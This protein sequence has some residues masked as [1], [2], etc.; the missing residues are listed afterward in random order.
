MR[1][2][3]R[4]ANGAS[5]LVYHVDARTGA[6]LRIEDRMKHQVAPATG[7][8]M[9]TYSGAVE[10]PTSLMA[11]GTYALFDTTRGT[12]P[13]PYLSNFTPDESGWGATGMQAWYEEHDAAGVAT[14]NAWL[15][16]SN[17]VNTWGDGQPFTA[18]GQE[19]G[20]NG[21][22]AGVDAMHGMAG[23]WDFF[24][25]VM[26]RNGMDGQ[27][28][29][30]FAQ[31]LETGSYNRD[32]ASWSPWYNGLFLGAGSW[33]GNPNGLSALS[34]FDV[35]A[36]EMTHGVTSSTV[37]FTNAPGYEEA[38]LDEATSDFFAQ[39]AKAYA[40]RAAED[41]PA[42]VP[43]TGADWRV[44]Y[45]AGHGTPIRWMDRPSKDQ[46]SP[47]G[48]YD[49]LLYLD[50]HY[51]SGPL[52]RALYFLAHGA[53]TTAGA[54]DFSVYMPQGMTGIGNDKAAHIWFV[55]VTERLYSGNTGT[56]T[57]A[58]ARK[59]AIEAAKNLYGFGWDCPESIAV[60]N[61]FGAVNV[62]RA[63]GEAPRTQ[64][65]FADW[66]DNDWIVRNHFSDTGYGHK[67]YLPMGVAVQPKITVLNNADT[68]VTWSTGG[69]SVYN[70]GLTPGM[71]GYVTGG[72]VINA[73]G[74]W[75]TP[76]E[77]GWF[78]ITATSKADPRQF[79]EGRAFI[80]NMDADGDNQQDAVD[81]GP[82]AF[83]WYLTQAVNPAHSM[84][85]API[86]DDAD[87]A[88]F[89]DAMRSTWWNK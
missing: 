48:W 80:I 8:G 39:M 74:A 62:G 35:V 84:F 29:T 71:L 21:Q 38:G 52:N 31:V 27:G 66:R 5:D 17:P 26:G 6:I 19:G 78:A 69:P 33:P 55:T 72:G 43:A 24:L 44:G 42:K 59:Q 18:W 28:T 76:L 23:A 65:L 60:E 15:F 7:T 13:N 46:R 1:A 14:G 61:A 22:S 57:Y 83:S 88:A 9:G 45:Q 67:Q 2:A 87:V 70:T 81:L 64:V 40:G 47:D 30:V 56:V 37:E 63:Y 4:G 36:H 10:I 51:S 89:V 49:G 3:L 50:G 86:V 25:N 79:A 73:D 53:S 58:E 77:K 82:I 85:N 41:D 12:R 11:D 16:Q 34:E 54:D 20:A 68:S 75:V 32:N